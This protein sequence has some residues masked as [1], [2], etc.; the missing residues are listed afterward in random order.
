MYYWRTVYAL[1]PPE[2]AMLRDARVS[3]MYIRF[4]DV[5]REEGSPRPLPVAQIA[6]RE[7]PAAALRVVPVV[8]ITVRALRALSVDSAAL[9]GRDI[10]G[11]ADR[12]ASENGIRFS[13][14][15]LDCDWTPSTREAFFHIARALR[16]AL[17]ARGARLSAT[18]RL[19]QAKYPDRAGVPPVD[20]GMLMDYNT[21]R[22][23][24]NAGDNSIYRDE[25][26]RAYL[27]SLARYPLP[28]DV[29]L[30]I[31]HWTLHF[32]GGAMAGILNRTSVSDIR[33]TDGL[34]PLDARRFLA[35][36]PLL[37][38]GSFLAA[39]DVLK[40]EDVPA[41]VCLA[42]AERVMRA[43][44]PAPRRVALFACDSVYFSRYTTDDIDKI[45][46]AFR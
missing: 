21:G 19:H 30:P 20:R 38:R 44:P 17:H 4:F 34:T 5:D 40:C 11:A 2:R 9:L 13:E 37:V 10:L 16:E 7:P 42:A 45:Y 26:A 33:D 23:R 43:L 36:R 28:L 18:I 14:F 35:A 39:G 24:P 31:F 3:A 29:V 32:R 27:A 15:Q 41:S 22:M 25:D 1:S 6:F 12:I 8:F 46:G